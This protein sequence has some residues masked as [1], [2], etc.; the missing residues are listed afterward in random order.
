ME[1]IRAWCQRHFIQP[2]T[3]TLCMSTNHLIDEIDS[4]DVICPKDWRCWQRELS[5]K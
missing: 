3:E 4:Q 1:N 2:Y 5:F